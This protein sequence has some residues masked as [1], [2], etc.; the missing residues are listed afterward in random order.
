MILINDIWRSCISL[1]ILSGL[2]SNINAQTVVFTAETKSNKICLRDKVQLQYTIKDAVNLRSIAKP[3]DTDFIIVGGPYE[4]QNT[5]T[6]Y[7]G[8]KAVQCSSISLTYMM[9]AKREGI[10][11]IPP[12]TAKD[13]AGHTYQSNAV[14]IQVVGPPQHSSA[15]R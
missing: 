6:S 9:I 4:M 2:S 5:S 10:F 12:V 1:F 14:T 3:C 13:S 11:I 8:T 7:V 15:S